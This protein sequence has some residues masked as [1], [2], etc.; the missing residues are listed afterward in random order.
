M[1]YTVGGNFYCSNGIREIVRWDGNQ[2]QPVGDIFHSA[3]NYVSDMIVYNGYLYVCGA[4]STQWGDGASSIARWDGISW[5]DIGGVIDDG[6]ADLEIFR[7]ELYVVSGFNT[8][9]NSIAAEHVAKWDGNQW[10]SVG[11]DFDIPGTPLTMAVLND[12]L[13]VGGYFPTMNN[14]QIFNSI[15]KYTD[16]PTSIEDV[17]GILKISVSP[18][19]FTTQTTI[20]LSNSQLST[21]NLQ[22]LLFDLL[23]KQHQVTYTIEA[24]TIKLQRG[25]LPGGVYFFQIISGNEILATGKIIVQ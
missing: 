12:E 25:N 22:L 1:N 10:Y 3:L 23:G 7:G 20:T 21:R 18:N 14:G 5:E 19:P 6:I 4:F 24:N 11:A 17:N 15:A 16:H 2:W 13:Y 8:I 9:G